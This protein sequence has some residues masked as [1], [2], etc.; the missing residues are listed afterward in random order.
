MEQSVIIMRYCPLMFN[1]RV[2]NRAV[3][4]LTP[5][6]KLICYA[7]EALFKLVYYLQYSHR[8]LLRYEN[9]GQELIFCTKK[10]L[11][12]LK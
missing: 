4:T 3:F 6:H 12:L 10:K 7:I 8:Q 2:Y 1:G 11:I 9:E 5:T